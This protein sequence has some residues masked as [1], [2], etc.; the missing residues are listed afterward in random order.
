MDWVKLPTSWRDDAAR[1]TAQHEGGSAAVILYIDAYLWA[2]Q[3][4]TDGVLPSAVVTLL[5]AGVGDEAIT[6]L[7][8]ARL[9][10][11]A[12]SGIVIVRYLGEQTSRGELESKRAATR[13]RVERH[14]NGA[15]DVTPLPTLLVTG[16]EV[17]VEVE[18]EGEGETTDVDPLSK[19]LPGAGVSPRTSVG[20]NAARSRRR[21]KNS[22]DSLHQLA[23]GALLGVSE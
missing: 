21:S 16:Q 19:V 15:K 3:H 11:R 14:R 8:D 20:S 18:V 13:K 4:E 17:E 12:K 6:A 1:L 9:W 2:A 23:A 22:T 7:L 5:S 10:K